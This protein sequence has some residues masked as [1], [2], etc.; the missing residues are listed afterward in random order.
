MSFAEIAALTI[1]DVKNRLAQL[2]GRAEARGDAETLHQ[3]LAAAASLTRLLTYY[4]SDVGALSPD[5]DGHAPAEMLADL[6][7]DA[8]AGGRVSIEIE[9]GAA[10]TLWFYDR[11]LVRMVLLNALQNAGRYANSS[12]LLRAAERDGM[13]VFTVV[14]DGPGYPA[15]VLQ[16]DSG[17]AAPVSRE[18]TGL[19][20]RLARRIAEQHENG[21]V[22]GRVV[23]ENLPGA[24]FSLWLP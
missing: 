23:L 1:H 15:A 8:A 5:I 13:L 6:A 7:V 17:A 12:I 11:E 18:G 19:G 3:V 9:A 20:L 21:G 14:D 10:P 4:R 22:R 16:D 2:A 24:C